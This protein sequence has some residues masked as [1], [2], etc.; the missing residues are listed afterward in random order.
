MG[1]ESKDKP[2]EEE[3]KHQNESDKELSDEGGP[4]EEPEQEEVE[5]NFNHQKDGKQKDIVIGEYVF[6]IDQKK[7]ALI[8]SRVDEDDIVYECKVLNP[9]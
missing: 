3:K 1:S 6:L 4:D 2:Q 7:Y 8:K 9:K 5:D